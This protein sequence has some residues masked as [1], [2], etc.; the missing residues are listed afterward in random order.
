[1]AGDGRENFDLDVVVKL[2]GSR[3]TN[4]T[5]SEDF[6]QLFGAALH[7]IDGAGVPEPKNRC[8][9]LPYPGEP[10]Y[11]DV[12]RRSHCPRTSPVP[13]FV[14]ATRTRYGVRPTQKTSQIPFQTSA[15]SHPRNQPD[16]DYPGD[17]GGSGLRR[18][19]AEPPV[20]PAFLH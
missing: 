18:S 8:W 6:F 17:T 9:R 4:L 19:P 13:T 7:G 3:F 20:W 2:S 5:E 16:L 10:F 1:M 15:G 14:Y 12:T 11:F